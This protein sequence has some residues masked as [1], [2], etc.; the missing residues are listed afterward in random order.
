M[1]LNEV[2]VSDEFSVQFL[3]W[4]NAELKRQIAE[5]E[6]M[7]HAP[8]LL[9]RTASFLAAGATAIAVWVVGLIDF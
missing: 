3:V 4:L 6:A 8:G 5:E 2:M 1:L 7:A 9:R